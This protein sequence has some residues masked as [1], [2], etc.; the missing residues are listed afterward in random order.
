MKLDAEFELGE[1]YDALI[2]N[3]IAE[4]MTAVRAQGFAEVS[5]IRDHPGIT[6]DTGDWF[7]TA[8]RMPSASDKGY[9]QV[10][11]EHRT[12][13]SWIDF[14]RTDKNSTWKIDIHLRG[15][16]YASNSLTVP[17]LTN[18]LRALMMAT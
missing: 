17:V 14:R 2:W 1:R 9:I 13:L 18:T 15:S 12:H 4:L 3:Q 5:S 6:R 10:R 7:L 8:L 16:P 11:M